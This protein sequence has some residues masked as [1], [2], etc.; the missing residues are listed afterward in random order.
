MRKRL[1]VTG[2]AAALVLTAGI[3]GAVAVQPPEQERQTATGASEP[4]ALQGLP[5]M[6][7]KHEPVSSPA[8]NGTVD[9]HGKKK[10]EP[11]KNPFTYAP[12]PK[13]ESTSPT[14]A[15]R[16]TSRFT[17]TPQPGT[18]F[19]SGVRPV[20]PSYPIDPP[21]LRPTNPPTPRPTPRPSP[22]PSPTLTPSPSPSPSSSPSPEP[23]AS[24]S[25]E[26]AE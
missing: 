19:G 4:D 2:T 17:I 16:P 7:L 9:V 13:P 11:P 8:E 12:A 6:M 1:I 5:P 24:P 14:Y 18:G 23:S 3:V 21:G 25:E 10:P 15:V 22:T 20:R 26:S